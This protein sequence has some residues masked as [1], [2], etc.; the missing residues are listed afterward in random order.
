VGAVPVISGVV[1]G[2][3]DATKPLLVLG[4]SLGTSAITLW[5]TAARTLGEDFQV[6]AWDLPG[7]G[8]SGPAADGFTMA[9]LALGVLRLV[10]NVLVERGEPGGSFTYA[11][12]SVG[13]AV[14]LQLLLDRPGRITAATLLCTGA[15]IGTPDGWK[16]RAHLVR[17]GGTQVIVEGAA[18][19][20]FA[21]GFIDREPEVATALLRA[22]RD[23]DR[24][25]YAWACEALARFDVR[26]R[27]H[28]IGVPVLAVA[29]AFDE[30]TPEQSLREI[31]EGVPE[32][33]LVLLD[34]VAHLAPAEAPMEVARL[35]VDQ[36][37]ASVADT[38]DLQD[39]ITPD[40]EENE[41]TP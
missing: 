41:A 1:L 5:G 7:H 25:S 29:G 13:G 27:L 18:A 35:I 32:G 15:R 10:E 19:R 20:W 14:G 9:E 30:P 2:D 33:R 4:P 23:A 40:A 3:G 28:E 36:G 21:P 11:G 38:R 8:K 17:S 24:F 31:A 39:L 34:D 6:L 37:T 22:L 26:P 16:E 12:D